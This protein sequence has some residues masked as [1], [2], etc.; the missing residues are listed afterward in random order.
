MTNML[1]GSVRKVL[2]KRCGL[3]KIC[4]E[5]STGALRK[6]AS[7]KS[8]EKSIKNKKTPKQNSIKSKNQKNSRK[9]KKQKNQGIWEKWPPKPFPETLGFFFVFF[10]FSRCFFC[11]FFSRLFWLLGFY[12]KFRRFF[13]T[14]GFNSFW[15]DTLVLCIRFHLTLAILSQNPKTKKTWRKQKK[16]GEK[17]NMR[18]GGPHSAGFCFFGGEK[19][20]PIWT[21]DLLVFKRNTLPKSNIDPE[22]WWLED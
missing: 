14:E 20:F 16:T 19:W 8:S 17:N 1:W 18:N 12:R 5:L 3:R 21:C 22:K 11:F 7:G 4:Y 2:W 10:W 15:K 9:Q 6:N 13:P